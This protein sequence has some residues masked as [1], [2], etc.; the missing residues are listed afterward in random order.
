MPSFLQSFPLPRS[1]R[2]HRHSPL[3]QRTAAAAA[4]AALEEKGG[5]TQIFVFSKLTMSHWHPSSV[6]E[7]QLEHLI[8]KGWLLP[9]LVAG[10]RVPLAEHM[11]P[12]SEPNEVVSFLAFHKR[13]LE[14]PA[15]WFLHGLLHE[16]KLELQHL[17]PSGVLHI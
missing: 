8:A 12:H 5:G 10:W 1:S 7:S 17:N 3:A 4:S 2:H 14:Y 11:V 13:G 6:K 15:H 9:K 16:W